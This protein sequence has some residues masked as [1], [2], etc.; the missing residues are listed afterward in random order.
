MAKML[1]WARFVSLSPALLDASFCFKCC[2]VYEARLSTAESMALTARIGLYLKALQ[3]KL[4]LEANQNG[5][6]GELIKR[7]Q[8]TP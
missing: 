2:R 6:A 1:F 5:R 8:T 3:H 7:F 4:R